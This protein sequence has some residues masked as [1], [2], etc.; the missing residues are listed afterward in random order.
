MAFTTGALP[1]FLPVIEVATADPD[2]MA[3]GY[4]LF[5]TGRWDLEAL[6]R[7]P[8]GLLV[9]LDPE[10]EVVWYH[11]NPPAANDARMTPAGTILVQYPPAGIREIDL[12]GNTLRAWTWAEPDPGQPDTVVVDT[13]A[14]I[15]S[16]HHEAY[17]T[18][19]GN[20]LTLALRDRELTGAQQ[21][22]CAEHEP[23]GIAEDVIVEF[24]PSGE[25]LHEWSLADV[26][27]PE[28]VPG[29]ALCTETGA[30]RD[31]A[32]AN[33][34]ILDP[35]NNTVIVSARHLDLVLGFRHEAAAAGPSGELLW[36]LGP[37]GTLALADGT[38]A[39]H[40]HA[41]ELTPGGSLLLYDNGNGRPGD[42]PFSRAVRYRLDLAGADPAQW[43]ARQ[44]WEH[45]VEDDSG[46]PV[47][48]DFLGDADLQPGGTVLIDHGGTGRTDGAP[49]ARILEVVPDG[50]RGGTIVFDV[51]LGP[52]YVSYRAERLPTL[53]AG[54][55]WERRPA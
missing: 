31:W 23:F 25:V 18:P 12:L 48:A 7:E 17:L 44:V 52:P 27:D 8:L 29:A 4:T 46:A 37:E 5:D 16:F 19:D 6:S 51:S 50:P 36:S 14:D 28:D 35:E 39:Y 34:V 22:V 45:R 15:R 20:L 10:G 47:Y 11:Q 38:Y 30:H 2:R 1:D 33:G 24:T 32:H 3:P 40:Q 42:L 49:Q 55:D 26:V 43:S 54:P 41:P 53:Y 21:A 9:A 13:V